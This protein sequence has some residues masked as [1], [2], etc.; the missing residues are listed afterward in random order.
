MARVETGQP[1]VCV[2]AAYHDWKAR[3]R[4][5][6]DSDQFTLTDVTNLLMRVGMQV[7]LCEGRPDSPNS[8]GMDWGLFQIEA[9]QKDSQAA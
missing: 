6:W 3:V 4:I 7:G 5:R 8:A 2:R 9:T 1:Y